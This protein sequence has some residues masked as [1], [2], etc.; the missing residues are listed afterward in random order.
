MNSHQ[1]GSARERGEHHHY[2]DSRERGDEPIHHSNEHSH[3]HGGAEAVDPMQLPSEFW[4]QRYAGAGSVW[5]GHVN[6]TLA[7][8]VGE[9]TPGRS[10]DLGCGE[11]GDVLWL[12]ERGWDASG[13]DLSHTAVD[14]A[15][16]VAADRGLDNAHFIAA[17]LGE[18]ADSPAT[19]DGGADPFDLVSASFFQSPVALRRTQILRAAAARVRPG[20]HLVVISHAVPP[21][22]GSDHPIQFVTVESELDALDLDPLTWEV[23]FA[24]TRT[25]AAVGTEYAE[26][27]G[28][29]HAGA[30]HANAD[31]HEHP[32][33]ALDDAVIVARKRT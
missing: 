26:G 29:E 22:G 1:Y 28:A 21:G 13:I 32:P 19:I 6:D 10:L 25:R 31:H 16:Q 8:V 23:L 14:R 18:W 7:A 11:G 30:E 3:E 5:S 9:W 12:A 17:D 4:E 20:G 33:H 24:Q 2:G 15:T 27:S